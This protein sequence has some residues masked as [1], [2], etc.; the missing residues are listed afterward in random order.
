MFVG[1][2][3]NVLMAAKRGRPA[4]GEETR[5]VGL[6]IRLSE[7]ERVEIRSACE[8]HGLAVAELILAYIRGNITPIQKRR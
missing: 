2:G 7:A 8:K 1:R 6:R 5:S 3:K 4:K